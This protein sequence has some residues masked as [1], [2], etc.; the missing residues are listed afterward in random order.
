MKDEKYFLK[1]V[2]PEN[3]DIEFAKGLLNAF[4]GDLKNLEKKKRPNMT[5]LKVNQ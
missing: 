2:N 3:D 5:V 4:N 1:I